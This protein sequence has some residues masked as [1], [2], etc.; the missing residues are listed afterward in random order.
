MK[1]K[2][3]KIGL[4]F[5]V[6][7]FILIWGFNFLKGRNF[8][9]QSN[10]YYGVYSRVEGLNEGSPIFYRGF[11][12][13]TVRKI[14]FN[15][16]NQ[17]EFVVTFHLTKNL[18]VTNKT[19]A[20]LYSVDLLGTKAIQFIN[21]G[22]FSEEGTIDF[23]P[24][25]TLKTSI[26]GALIDQVSTEVLPLKD[27]VENLIIS[28]DSVL[29]NIGGIFNYENKENINK[30]IASFY[31]TVI[32]LEE[33]VSSINS[34]LSSA[35]N[36][37]KSFDNIEDFTAGL[38]AQTE[39]LNDIASNL[40]T[41]S[42][43]LND[44]DVE[45]IIANMDSAVYNLNLLIEKAASG[46]GT[47]GML[48]EDKTLYLN[49]ADAAANLDRL[50]MDMRHHPGRYVNFSAINIGKKVYQS[51]DE[52]SAEKQGI[53]FKVKIAE[54]ERPLENLKNKTIL[55]DMIIFEDYDGKKYIYTV[56]ETHSYNTALKLADQLY[57]KYPS[58]KIIA[59]QNGNHIKLSKAVKKTKS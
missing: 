46:E 47:L 5:A 12:I 44:T 48:M 56:G 6:S 24:G 37:Q 34:S 3:V 2:E 15:S 36:L 40:R 18:S 1:R 53:V 27:K 19:I 7:F 35:G 29:T 8:F 10:V 32:S 59:L 17:N 31:R 55:D 30:A 42:V 52:Q 23:Y 57:E 26:M 50:M 51:P 49:L 41:F 21:Y 16:N 54:S 13:G 38:K 39:N 11:K 4:M 20:Q 22:D 45:G 9:L 43:R 25:D 28:L 33:S 14:E 58:A